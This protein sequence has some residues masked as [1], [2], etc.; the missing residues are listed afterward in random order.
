MNR[1]DS[2]H[3]LRAAGSAAV[4]A[5]LAGVALFSV[6]D[7]VMK[8]L[9]LVIGAYN[10]LLFRSIVGSLL[11]GTAMIAS[12]NRWPPR[13]VLAL[14][15]RRGIVNTAMGWLFFWA[16]TQLPLAEA[17]ALSFVAPII[18]LY[19]AAI[20]LGEAVGKTAI[21][22]ALLGLAGV[23]IILSGRLSGDY[24]ESALWGALAVIG[25]AVL[26]AYNLV[27][28]RQL[29]QQ[30]GMVEMSFFQNGMTLA[31]LL[32][33][34]PFLAV[35]PLGGQW[36]LVVGAAVLVILSQM[37]LAWAYAR[38][39]ASR[40]IP[41]EYS[42]FVWASIMGWLF[43]AEHLSLAVV[44]GAAVIVAACLIAARQRPEMAAHVEA[45]TA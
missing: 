1:V 28:Q 23:G 18:A 15:V 11:S 30:A 26:F 24:Q 43:F 19:L 12:G 35:V 40:L 31:L 45:D 14:H 5:C 20:L 22:S 6:M 33:F 34:L 44:A 17:I 4:F 38:A 16:L 8:M 25:S 37:C 41:L 2:A 9:A 10:A 36:A 21:L 39:P 3:L 27:L 7:V 29:A 42:A 13:P 32:P